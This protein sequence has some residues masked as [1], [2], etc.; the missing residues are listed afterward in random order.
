MSCKLR[1]GL[2]APVDRS[3]LVTPQGEVSMVWEDLWDAF[4]DEN[5]NTDI[6]QAYQSFLIT[7]SESFK[8]WFSVSKNNF[9]AANN[10]KGPLVFRDENGNNA[11]F[12]R[13]DPAT[14]TIE[15]WNIIDP[16]I[17]TA[18][19]LAPIGLQKIPGISALQR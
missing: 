15:T 4:T 11:H 14:K 2:T 16:S 18:I 10:Q 19:N 13:I 3:S 8:K 1:K 5:G 9:N 7:E 17:E 12:R 6:V